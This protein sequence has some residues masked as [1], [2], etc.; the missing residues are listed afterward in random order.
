[1]SVQP[2]DLTIPASDALPLAASLFEPASP[3]QAI[4]VGSAT[5]VPRG[6]YRSVAAYLA[7]CGAAVLT[8]DYRGAGEPPQTLRSS[9]ARM[10]DWGQLDFAGAIAWTKARYPGLPLHVLGH[11]H[12][13]HALLLAPNNAEID[14]AVTV[15]TQLGYWRLCAPGE[16][17]RVWLLLNA[18]APAAIALYGY[19]PGSKLGLGE[20]LARGVMGEWRRWCN[21]PNYFFDDPSMMQPLANALNFRAPTLVAGVADDLWGTRAAVDA[22]AAHVANAERVT[23]DPRNYGLESVG[24]FG[25][26]RSR[27]GPA[28]WPLV[29]RYFG[30]EEKAA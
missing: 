12:G 30:L 21:S 27:N 29:A 13:G 28:L 8:Y 5:A 7:Q 22:Y 17:Y 26:F 10:R 14:R 6:F 24:H 3:Q 23:I 15:A 18:F 2:R 19:V 1:M 25:F 20:D 11:S 4:I 16:R 9:S